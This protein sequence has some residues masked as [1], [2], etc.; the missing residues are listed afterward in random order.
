MSDEPNPPREISCE[1]F[2]KEGYLLEL[3]RQFL[4][5]LGL[6]M[7][8]K[9]NEET[10]EMAWGGVYDDRD[11]LEG[12]RY[13]GPVNEED[14]ADKEAKMTNITKI[15]NDRKPV[16]VSTLGYWIQPGEQLVDDDTDS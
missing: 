10:G 12:W 9:F 1:E 16:R 5:P 7:F 14:R 3:N 15:V 4:H 13:I 2:I 11:D 6:A 8:Y